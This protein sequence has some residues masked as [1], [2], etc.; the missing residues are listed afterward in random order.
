MYF[1][2]NESGNDTEGLTCIRDAIAEART[3]ESSALIG[4]V[5][6][7]YDV[8]ATSLQALGSTSLAWGM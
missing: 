1:K 7:S 8:G 6:L 2:Q 5:V 3:H 4:Y